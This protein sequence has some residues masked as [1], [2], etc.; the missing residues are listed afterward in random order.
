M[1]LGMSTSCFYCDREVEDT[2]ELYNDMGVGLAEVFLN[3]ESEYE[4]GFV[5]MLNEKKG[6]IKI[7]SV[8]PHGT[9]FEPELF[10]NHD[11][12]RVDAEKVFSKVCH[13]GYVLGAKYITFHGPFVKAGRETDIDFAEF[14]ARMNQICELAATFGMQV[15][16]ENVSWAYGNKPE[17]FSELLNYCP[18]LRATLDTKQ[19]I[20]SGYD[21]LRFAD[22]MGDRLVTIH[23]C[24]MDRADHPMLPFE[25][26][27]NFERFFRDLKRR[28]LKSD[29]NVIIEVYRG[30]FKEENQL[31]NCFD[32][33]TNMMQAL[34]QEK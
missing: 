8:H 24:D 3:C 9:S 11:R 7:H 27:I 29:P 4:D 12:T 23:L 2:L 20:F 28:N 26:K 25:G 19:A 33:L 5:R 18:D 17:F 10:S 34:K 6:S 22:A 30:N 13:A 31:K 14:G 1:K 15:A 32:K 16:Y 21:P